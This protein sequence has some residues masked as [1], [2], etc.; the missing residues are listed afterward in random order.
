[1]KTNIYRNGKVHVMREMCETCIFRT[2]SCIERSTV[3]RMIK[4][5]TKHDSTIICHETLGLKDKSACYG[6]FK[7]HATSS[8]QIADRLGVIQ[9]CAPA[10]RP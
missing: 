9:F 2:D 3:A 7:L 10:E 4:K 8:L 5:A 6:F 1:M